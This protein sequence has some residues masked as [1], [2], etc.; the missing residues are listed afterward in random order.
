MAFAARQK[1]SSCLA[2][3]ARRLG[4]CLAFGLLSFMV[5]GCG[6]PRT[7]EQRIEQQYKDNP[8]LKRAK[9]APFAGTVTIDGNEPHLDGIMG[10]PA[11]LVILRDPK[12]QW[13][14]SKPLQFAICDTHGHFAFTS[15]TKDD[16][17]LP[18]SYVVLFAQLVR[19]PQNAFVGP[20]RLK[21]LYNDPD[22]NAKNPEFV[23]ELKPPGKTDC[24]F[25]LK[26]AGENPVEAPKP[27]AVTEIRSGARRR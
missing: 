16:G 23:I 12:Q 1:Q 6:G 3:H 20:D 2:E 19:R 11:V 26:V 24:A 4:L 7:D 9:L 18:G 14:P 15:S 22:V 17:A 21:N 13:D 5:L 25:E 27:Q 8:Q 10:K